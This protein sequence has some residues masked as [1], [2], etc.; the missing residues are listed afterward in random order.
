LLRCPSLDRQGEFSF[1]AGFELRGDELVLGPAR[2]N[3]G[4]EM[5]QM[6]GHR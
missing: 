3:S 6:N 2:P 1:R 4:A 5:K